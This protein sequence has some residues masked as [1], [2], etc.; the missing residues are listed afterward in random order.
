MVVSTDLDTEEQ[1]VWSKNMI[2]KISGVLEEKNT[3]QALIDV[4]GLSYEVEKANL[5]QS[6]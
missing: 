6:Q 1:N 5:K 3:H 4:N 2:G